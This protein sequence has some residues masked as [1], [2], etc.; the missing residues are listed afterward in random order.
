MDLDFLVYQVLPYVA[1]TTLIVGSV[2]RYERDPFTWK[3]SSTQL[4]RRKQLIWGS[5]LFHIGVLVIA[6]GHLGGLLTPIWVFD[7]VGISHSAKQIAAIVGG[8]IAAVLA[9]VGGAMLLHRRLFD[10]RIR[11]NSTLADTGI[12]ILL[13]FQLLLG[14]GTIGVSIQHLSGD[15]MVKF[16]G[17]AQGLATFRMDAYALVVDVHWIFKLHLFFGM[18]TMIL[19]PFTRLVH[20]FSAPLSYLWRPGFQVVRSRR[21][22]AFAPRGRERRALEARVGAA[23]PDAGPAPQPAE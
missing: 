14:I 11:A 15:E 20:I 16:M 18:V 22:A 9:L 6:V 3:S 23:R 8:G 17:W 19:V 2:A 21:R 4:L 12:L 13:L 5:I 10:P 1:L 7:A